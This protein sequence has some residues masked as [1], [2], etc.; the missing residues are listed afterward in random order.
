MVGQFIIMFIKEEHCPKIKYLK[1]CKV[2]TGFS[3]I[4]GNKGSV[5]IRFQFENTSFAFTN[6]HLTSGQ[7]EI[8]QRFENIRLIENETFNDFSSCNT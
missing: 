2:K 8:N 5:A 6:V 3:G 7:N 4:A 1:K